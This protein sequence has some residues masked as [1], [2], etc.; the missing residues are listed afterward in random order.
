MPQSGENF[1]LSLLILHSSFLIPNFFSIELIVK[2]KVYLCT[3]FEVK[4]LEG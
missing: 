4:C 3:L 1:Y 2:K